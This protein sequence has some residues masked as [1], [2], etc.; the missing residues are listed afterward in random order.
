MSGA[1]AYM[2]LESGRR[3]RKYER[4]GD[5]LH[6]RLWKDEKGRYWRLN[7]RTGTFTGLSPSIKGKKEKYE[8]KGFYDTLSHIREAHLEPAKERVIKK[9]RSVI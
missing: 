2:V 5:I 8:P 1:A 9:I 7:E 6:D 3:K 4:Q